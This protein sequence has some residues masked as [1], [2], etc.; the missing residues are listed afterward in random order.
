MTGLVRYRHD[1]EMVLSILSCMLII[2][3]PRRE[4]R[5]DEPS[6]GRDAVNK[7]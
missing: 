2:G 4:H 5:F 6:V 3:T 7:P 1:G